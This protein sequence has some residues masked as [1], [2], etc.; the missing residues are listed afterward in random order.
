[1]VVEKEDF[2]EKGNSKNESP[3]FIDLQAKHEFIHE[4]H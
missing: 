3:F 4:I 1:M 2:N